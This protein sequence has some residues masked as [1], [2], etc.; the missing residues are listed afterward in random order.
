MFHL[1]QK[2]RGYIAG[3]VT[4][5]RACWEQ[6]AATNLQMLHRVTAIS[7]SI[8]LFYLIVSIL[9]DRPMNMIVAYSFGFA[10]Q[11][12]FALLIHFFGTRLSWR[13]RVIR[14]LCVLFLLLLLTVIV[15]IGAIGM[16]NEPGI[17][18]SPITIVVSMLFVLPLWYN[19]TIVTVATV[20]FVMLSSHYKTMD[21]YLL[22]VSMAVLT[23]VLSLTADFVV[24]D[25]R[26]RD[27]N[28]RRELMLLSCTDSLTGL[29][30]RK[31]RIRGA[32]VPFRPGQAMQ[33]RVFVIDL[34]Q[35]KQINDQM[36]ISRATPR[37]RF[38][39]SVA[40]TLSRRRY[41]GPRRRRR[42]CGA[43]EKHRRP[44]AG[45]AS[46]R[47][48]LRNRAPYRFRDTGVTLT[49]SVGVAISSEGKL[50]L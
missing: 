11:V 21:V 43:D 2:C 16:R 49:C 45:C 12:A 15:H 4:G 39:G 42:V 37:W 28:Q 23:W 19:V 8:F 5:Y 41:R 25:L 14:L 34:D 50:H 36:D 35:F 32:G 27:M 1:I 20:A 10:S 44:A 48:D 33:F 24:L 17:Y 9:S 38:L 26:I 29:R 18:F 30:T 22:D 7:A 47:P 13:T 6:I 3:I 46:R 40:E 31:G